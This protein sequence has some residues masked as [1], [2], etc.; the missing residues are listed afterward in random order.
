MKFE[1]VTILSI[2]RSDVAYLDR[3]L[4][5]ED[6][7]MQLLPAQFYRDLPRD[8]LRA[9]AAINA[10]YGIPTLEL[11]NWLK[12]AIG[13]RKAIEI[14]AGCGDLGY[15][16]GIPMT[17]SYQQVTNPLTVAYY[18]LMGQ[19]PTRPPADVVK[20]DAEA[21]V[22]ARK[23]DVVVASWVTERFLDGSSEGNIHGPVEENIVANCQTYIFI[24]NEGVHGQKRILSLPHST[25]KFPW[26]VSRSANQTSNVIY[27]W[28]KS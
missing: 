19:T 5:N 22:L 3:L 17:D 1:N 24:G 26:L 4:L 20:E 16:L 18:A 6:G 9:W 13:P 7:R 21:A 23:P 25:F 8:H 15:H 27:T 10:R 2:G 12:V 14:G 11:V 28:D